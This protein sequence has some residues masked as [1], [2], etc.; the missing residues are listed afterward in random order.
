M[1]WPLLETRAPEERVGANQSSV[2]IRQPTRIVCW[3]NNKIVQAVPFLPVLFL[4]R[5]DARC[6][7]GTITSQVASNHFVMN[8]IP[9]EKL[10]HRIILALS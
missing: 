9:E 2:L 8:V 1:L 10:E 5:T 7:A 6:A 4:P 3:L